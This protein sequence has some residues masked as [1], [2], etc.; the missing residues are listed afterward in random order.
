MGA[1]D[2]VGALAGLGGGDE[3]GLEVL[4]DGLDVHLDV[5]GLTPLGGGLLDRPRVLVVGPDGE[6]D[7]APRA[8]S[9]APPPAPQPARSS[10]S[11]AIR[12]A[13]VVRRTPMCA[14]STAGT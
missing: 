4:G 11:P 2:Q 9:D 13:R 3:H 5:V 14:P 6:R 7:A 8:A 1:H 12:R 10:I